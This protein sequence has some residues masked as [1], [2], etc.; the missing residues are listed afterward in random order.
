MEYIKGVPAL[1]EMLRRQPVALTLTAAIVMPALIY[2]FSRHSADALSRLATV[3]VAAGVIVASCL[4]AKAN[5]KQPSFGA[6]S[7]TWLHF[8]GLG[9]CG[10]FL[11]A[12][13]GVLA[14]LLEV[15]ASLLVPGP[16]VPTASAAVGAAVML[17]ATVAY[18][19]V[20]GVRPDSV[21]GSPAGP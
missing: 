5:I 7:D 14:M 8:F 15:P 4:M 1:R 19:A 9:L 12:F 10:L 20:D 16:L 2:F 11:A 13:G 3:Q 18:V 21:D 6:D 17:A